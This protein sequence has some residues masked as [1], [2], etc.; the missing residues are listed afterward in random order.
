MIK[1]NL[2]CISYSSVP[3]S[4]QHEQDILDKIYEQ[5]SNNPKISINLILP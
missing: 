2:I 5:G 3:V 1:V 4:W